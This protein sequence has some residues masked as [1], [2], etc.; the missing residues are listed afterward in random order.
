[1]VAL[2]YRAAVHDPSR[3]ST[4]SKIGPWAGLTLSRSQSGE[5]YI[6][7]GITMAGDVYLRR[8]LC[9][10]ATVMMH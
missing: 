8:A 6:S 2:S 3:F 5:R 10:A 1:M 9:Q 7:G 4:S